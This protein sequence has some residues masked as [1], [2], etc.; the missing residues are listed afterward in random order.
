MYKLRELQKDDIPTLNKWRNDPELIACLGAPFRFINQDVDYAWFNSYMNS[1]NKNVRCAILNKNNNMIGVVSLVN[2]DHLNQSCELHIMIGDTV[3]REKGAGSFAVK[4]MLK[5]AF[6]NLNLQRVE[7][8]VL[9]TNKEAISF[10]EKVGFTK[11]G[12][13]RMAQYKNGEFVDMQLYSIL[14][15]EFIEE[16]S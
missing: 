1:R 4:E 11:E 2:I 16:V 10:Y 8:T 12:T 9:D 5:H 13:K 3:N 6:M 15:F 7:L 14:R